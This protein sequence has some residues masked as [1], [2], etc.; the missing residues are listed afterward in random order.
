ME[1]TQTQRFE[2]LYHFPPE[3]ISSAPGRIN[4]IGEHTDYNQGYVLPA[5][6]HLRNYFLVSKNNENKIYIFT[7]NFKEKEVFSIQKIISTPDKN[8]IN[9]IKGIF[10]I[11]KEQGFSVQGI[12]GF[13]SSDIPLEAGLSSS[14]ALE[15]DD[16]SLLGKLLFQSHQSLRDD[17][18]VS[19]PELDLLNEVGKR[20]SGCLGARLIGGGFGGSG[21]ALLEKEKIKKFKN[22]VLEEGKKRGFSQPSFYK[23][24]I[25]DGARLHTPELKTN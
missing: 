17:Y 2:G 25:G 22:E 16:F 3:I 6:I 23:V 4:I 21:L 7:E 15:K 20:F 18:Q 8:W 10:W 12:N 24:E 5:A 1:K 13:I 11:L 19:C 9:Y 14:A